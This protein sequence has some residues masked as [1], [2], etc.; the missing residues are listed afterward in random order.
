MSRRRG[1]P[2][3]RITILIGAIVLMVGTIARAAEP[4][5]RFLWVRTILGP[6]C[7]DAGTDLVVDTDGGVLIAGYRGGLD[8]DRDGSVDIQTFGSPDPLVLKTYDDNVRGWVQG[9]GGPKRDDARGIASDRR[10]GA[11]AVGEFRESMRI[12]GGTIASAGKADGFVARYDQGGKALWARPVGGTEDDQLLDVAS[13]AAGN[14]LVI[15]TVKGAVDVDRDG[16]LEVAGGAASAFLLASFNPEGKLRWAR[17]SG[18]GPA[19]SGAGATISAAVH[20]S[21]IAVG[22]NDEIYVA[23]HYSNGAADLDGDGS[24][25]VVAA[26]R[27]DASAAITPQDD[28][29]GFYARFEASGEMVWAKEVSG[30]AVQGVS[31]LAMAGNG[32][33]LVLGGF[34]GSADLDGDGA[35]DLELRSLGDRQAK[36]HADANSFLLRVTPDGKRVWARR[37]E[38]SALHVAADASRIVLSGFYNGPLDL[39]GDGTPERAADEDPRQEGFAAVLDG[40]G[41]VLHVFTIVGGDADV[42]NAAGFSHDGK[43]LYVTG[44]TRL[45]ADFD[46]DGA[47]ETASACHQLGDL[48]LA[49]YTVED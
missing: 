38:A 13:D 10:G 23:G 39:D 12:A 34:T 2:R 14:V 15:G 5:Y 18:G 48:F 43:K 20:G 44:Y 41:R 21:A 11:Y 30:P 28:L 17:V 25:D 9:P 19:A 37:F 16:T 31:S 47:I 42:A 40:E 35:H 29:N 7:G 45:G 3:L 46:A 22:P 24:P 4:D 6:C 26:T 49:S 1:R 27:R 32:D 33:L 36:H 8:L